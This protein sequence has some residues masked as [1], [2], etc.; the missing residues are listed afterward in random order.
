MDTDPRPVGSDADRAATVGSPL[1]PDA[2]IAKGG[3]GWAY[4]RRTASAGRT[5]PAP[6]ASSSRALRVLH[7]CETAKGG[8]GTYLETMAAIGPAGAENWFILPSRHAGSLDVGRGALVYRAEARGAG[9]LVRLALAVI[10]ALRRQAPDI[11]FAHSSLALP[12][13]GLIRLLCWSAA[14]AGRRPSLLYCAHGWAALAHPEGS[15][16]GALLRVAERLLASAADRILCISE[17][18]ADYARSIGHGGRIAVVESAVRDVARRP[19]SDLFASPEEE[20]L[21][22]LF[23]GRFDRQK[24]LDILVRAFDR[25]RRVRPELRLHVVGAAVRG[26]CQPIELPPGIKLAGWIGGDRI[27][28]WYASADALIVPSRWEAFGLVV[29]EALRN[30]T[31]VL[32]SDRGALPSLVTPGTTGEVFPL[33][34]ES[35]ATVLAGVDRDELRR[36][37]KACRAAYEDRFGL[38]AFRTRVRRLY[39]DLLGLA[40]ERPAT[41]P[42]SASARRLPAGRPG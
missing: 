35:L 14:V 1:L 3:A 33:D 17:H 18:E 2:L 38:E 15:W 31:P 32:C 11:V 8:V 34:E 19:R 5:P 29:P 21:N 13:L 23:V 25:A 36:R 7:F 16:K 6:G 12:V 40:R 30:G 20:T 28:D 4:W 22:L 10:G 27:D 24:G 9:A 41:A 26:D 37:R 42:A 39:D